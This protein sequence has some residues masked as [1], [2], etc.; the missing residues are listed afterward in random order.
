MQLEPHIFLMWVLIQMVDAIGIKGRSAPL[1]A[2][3]TVA[4]RQQQFSQIGTILSRDA[5]DQ[6]RLSQDSSKRWK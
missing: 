2:M 5:G 6:R 3:D 1:D 4:F